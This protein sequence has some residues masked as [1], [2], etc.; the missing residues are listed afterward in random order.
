M[1]RR[2][3]SRDDSVAAS[4]L[5]QRPRG[6]A[7]F[8]AIELLGATAL[9]SLLVVA[10]LGVITSLSRTRP[11]SGRAGIDVATSSQDALVE[12]VRSDLIHA[13]FLRVGAKAVEIEGFS[14]IDPQ[15]LMPQH[16]PVRV[17]YFLNRQS[18]SATTKREEADTEAAV[19]GNWLMRQQVDVNEPTNRRSWSELVCGGVADFVLQPIRATSASYTD[20]SR[21][22]GG[23]P[24]PERV[25]LL[26]R[27]ADPAR[28]AL[29]RVLLLY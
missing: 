14:R 2:W 19:Q 18:P 16:Q 21:G 26:L 10:L 7:G 13:R 8:T 6:S 11:G 17:V 28:P 5:R 1:K 9:L 20:D 22:R 24:P 27:W 29:D 12:L 4:C 3:P 23:E 25:R 15:T